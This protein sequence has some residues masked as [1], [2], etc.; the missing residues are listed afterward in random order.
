MKIVGN[1]V[2]TP[3]PRTDFNQTDPKKADYLKGREFLATKED[4]ESIRLPTGGTAG[5]V[6]TKTEKGYA[7]ADITIPSNYGKI[8]YTQDKVIQIV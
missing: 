8:S 4:L 2:G 3:M 5:Q 6:L 1:T 7:W